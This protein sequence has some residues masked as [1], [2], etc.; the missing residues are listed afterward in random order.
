MEIVKMEPCIQLKG[1]IAEELTELSKQLTP[2][3]EE[4]CTKAH[5]LI[6]LLRD[7]G[8]VEDTTKLVDIALR[9]R[10]LVWYATKR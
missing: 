1:K 2:T 6:G 4:L 3:R 8:T 10:N 5:A 9:L 7:G